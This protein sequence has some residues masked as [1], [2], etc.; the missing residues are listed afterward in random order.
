MTSRKS[1]IVQFFFSQLQ[2]KPG[3]DDYTTNTSTTRGLSQLRDWYKTTGQVNKPTQRRKTAKTPLRVSPSVEPTWSKI[4]RQRRSMRRPSSNSPRGS[5]KRMSKSGR[6]KLPSPKRRSSP[7]K[8]SSK[9]PKKRRGSPDKKKRGSRSSSRSPQ[10][11]QSPRR[12]KSRKAI[13][14]G[15]DNP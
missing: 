12:S 15:W 14:Y 1:L 7:R 13:R 10:K 9:S 5:P 3:M 2:Y 11:K 4:R 8:T 6:R